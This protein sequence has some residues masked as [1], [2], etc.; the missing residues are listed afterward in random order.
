MV[1]QTEQLRSEFYTAVEGAVNTTKLRI[2]SQDLRTVLH[3]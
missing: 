3:R 2:A 1:A